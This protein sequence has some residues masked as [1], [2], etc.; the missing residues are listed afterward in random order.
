MNATPK[1]LGG[2]IAIGRIVHYTPPGFAGT[3]GSTQAAIVC[4]VK[5]PDIGIVNLHV[6]PNGSA[7]FA[8]DVEY[9]ETPHPNTWRWPARKP[10]GQT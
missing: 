8:T 1:K 6:F 5:N 2:D 10:H 7:Y 4:G 3:M 9:S